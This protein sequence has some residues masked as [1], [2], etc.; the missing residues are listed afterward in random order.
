MS[1]RALLWIVSAGCTAA[2]VGGAATTL[3]GR[4]DTLEIARTQ[5][6]IESDLRQMYLIEQTFREQE[7]ELSNYV[8]TGQEPEGYLP[9]SSAYLFAQEVAMTV[10][11]A[12]TP[13]VDD[14]RRSELAR[15]EAVEALLRRIEADDPSAVGVD[16]YE[17][18]QDSSYGP[19][20]DLQ[21][22]T[23]ELWSDQTVARRRIRA[24]AAEIGRGTKL[25]AGGGIGAVLAF[26][27]AARGRRP[28]ASTPQPTDPV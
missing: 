26:A 25:L 11:Q 19:L 24:A 9:P 4:S 16:A 5:R 12:P 15:I 28:R 27:A 17:K 7:S 23:F 22:I 10:I 3:A 20:F 14:L 21:D 18:L 8:I 13:L 2:I 6:D 1:T